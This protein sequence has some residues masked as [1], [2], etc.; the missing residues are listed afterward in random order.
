MAALD[1][2]GMSFGKWTVLRP[3]PGRVRYFVCRCECGTERP[4]YAGNLN[5]GLSASCGC[6][7]GPAGRR[8]LTKHGLADSK[9]HMVWCSMKARC[10][11]PSNKSYVNYGARG[12]VVCE[13][14]HSFENFWADMGATY[15]PGLT[16]ERVDNEK[17]Y[18]P[19]NCKWIPK[20]EQSRNTRS[21]VYIET[22]KGRMIVADAARAFG[23][24][25][26]ALRSRLLKGWTGARLFKP[27]GRWAV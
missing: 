21:N 24:S 3:F 19:D 13:A 17:G 14:W 26:S 5:N 12:I 20:A 25:A 27:S 9:P 6:T 2:S 10:H 22:S 15:A 1:L 23:I 18:G 11:N 16:L 7:I 8:R 4:V